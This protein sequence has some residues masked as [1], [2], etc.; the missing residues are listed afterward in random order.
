VARDA[1]QKR[2]CYGKVK[3]PQLAGLIG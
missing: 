3:P 1:A 2:D